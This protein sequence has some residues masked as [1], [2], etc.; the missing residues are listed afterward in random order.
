[1]PDVPTSHPPGRPTLIQ[2]ALLQVVILTKID[3]GLHV[4]QSLREGEVDSV[5]TQK[6][7][8]QCAQV[9]PDIRGQIGDS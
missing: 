1:M 6:P 4:G 2:D 8:P 5:I 9:Q 7:T 3:I